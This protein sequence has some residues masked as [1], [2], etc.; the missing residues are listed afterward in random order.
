VEGGRGPAGPY[1]T[2]DSAGNRSA[3]TPAPSDE[4]YAPDN[5]GSILRTIDDQTNTTTGTWA[6]DPDGSTTSTTGTSTNPLRYAS[7]YLAPGGLYHFGQRYYAPRTDAG[8]NKT[9]STKRGTF[10][11][12]TG[13]SMPARTR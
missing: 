3:N 11:R 7:G 13:T 5:L 8:H 4:D 6:Y 1:L 12:R 10:S 2:R 9:H